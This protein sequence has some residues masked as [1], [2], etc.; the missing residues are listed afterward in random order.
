MVV[1]SLFGV[2]VTCIALVSVKRC[3][4]LA[5]E[6]RALK[7]ILDTLKKGVDLMTKD[8]IKTEREITNLKEQ[9]SSMEICVQAYSETVKEFTPEMQ[10]AKMQQ[11]ELFEEWIGG[12]Y[13]L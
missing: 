13:E 6:V 10:K 3:Y 7:T 12:S 5:K 2:V 11:Q 9:I 1:I 4:D 8:L